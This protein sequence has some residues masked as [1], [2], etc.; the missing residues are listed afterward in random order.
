MK[1][2]SLTKGRLAAAEYRQMILEESNSARTFHAISLHL[3][4]HVAIQENSQLE[5]IDFYSAYLNSILDKPVYMH[6]PSGFKQ[7]YPHGFL[8]PHS[9]PF[10]LLSSQHEAPWSSTN[11]STELI[12]RFYSTSSSQLASSHQVLPFIFSLL[13]FPLRVFEST[14]SGS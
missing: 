9:R 10:E 12:R 3:L 4:L 7:V 14:R 6:V 2:S 13:S 5:S 11:T 1:R 8:W